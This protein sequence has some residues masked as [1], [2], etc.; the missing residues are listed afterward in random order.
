MKDTMLDGETESRIYGGKFRPVQVWNAPRP[1]ICGVPVV[2]VLAT[3]RAR[4]VRTR[5]GTM[6]RARR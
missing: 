6:H 2:A 1:N 3:R 5:A 4:R